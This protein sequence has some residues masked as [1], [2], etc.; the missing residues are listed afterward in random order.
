L[1]DSITIKKFTFF[2]SNS[3]GSS[4]TS[5]SSTVSSPRF[6]SPDSSVGIKFTL[7]DPYD[8]L[9]PTIVILDGESIKYAKDN[10]FKT[11][12]PINYGSAGS[13]KGSSAF[14]NSGISFVSKYLSSKSFI[15]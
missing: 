5:A 10:N 14:T 9:S 11:P 15:I 7:I 2:P 1:A 8:P 6:N 3:D 12:D 4:I 13:Q